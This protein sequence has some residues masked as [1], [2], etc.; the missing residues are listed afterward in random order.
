MKKTVKEAKQPVFRKK[1]PT[2]HE[3][4]EED[5]VEEPE[6]EGN[7]IDEEPPL[8]EEI[9]HSTLF[10]GPIN[11]V[12]SQVSPNIGITDRSLY[13]VCDFAFDMF[14]QVCLEAEHLCRANNRGT[15]T[16]R[17]IQTA[18]RLVLHGE[19]AKHAV[20]EGTK[21]L[22]KFNAS[23]AENEDNIGGTAGLVFPIERIHKL[24]NN[25]WLGRVGYGSSIYLAAVLEYLSAEILELAGNAA[26]IDPG[27]NNTIY[28]RHLML[29]IRNDEELDKIC[30]R[31][32]IPDSGGL[33]H[34]HSSFVARNN[35]SG[36][37]GKDKETDPAPQDQIY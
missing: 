13:I 18:V 37:E 12:L 4:E 19:L 32:I 34:I 24:I 29:A 11:K 7:E 28:P 31:S 30:R 33:P 22:T 5:E 23:M 9:S 27:S 16:S 14:L 21:A 2:K 35:E 8:G 15:I 17:E 20:S 3:E 10:S 25:H 1:A 6:K 26:R 36:D